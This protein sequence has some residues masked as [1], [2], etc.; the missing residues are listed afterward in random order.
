MPRGIEPAKATPPLRHR[1]C[2][3]VEAVRLGIRPGPAPTGSPRPAAPALLR[4]GQLRHVPGVVA[5]LLTADGAGD[6]ARDRDLL[7][8]LVRRSVLANA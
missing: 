6:L 8:I 3:F 5:H 7:F 4:R 2:P 1:G